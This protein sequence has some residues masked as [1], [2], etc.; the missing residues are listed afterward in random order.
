MT[1]QVIKKW[2]RVSNNVRFHG[3]ALTSLERD[4]TGLA[5]GIVDVKTDVMT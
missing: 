3:H 5:R 1:K 4:L 2:G